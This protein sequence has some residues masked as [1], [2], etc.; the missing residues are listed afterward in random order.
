MP[1]KVLKLLP[2][3]SMVVS[4]LAVAVQFHHTDAPPKA[5]GKAPGMDGSP[6]PP[7]PNCFVAPTLLPVVVTMG[8][9]NVMALTKRSLAGAWAR[10]VEAASDATNDRIKQRMMVFMNF[11]WRLGT[12]AT[13]RTTDRSPN[14]P[15]RT[16]R[17]NR[18]TERR[19]IWRV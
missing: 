16:F 18:D 5:P 17:G 4:P 6:P 14:W 3:V 7:P 19:D 8:P 15:S 12:T 1:S 9:F 10:A 11:I 2:S 13:Q